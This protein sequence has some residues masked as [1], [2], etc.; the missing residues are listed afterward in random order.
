MSIRIYHKNLKILTQNKFTPEDGGDIEYYKNIGARLI[1][2][3][4]RKNNNLKKQ[5]KY[6]KDFVKLIQSQKIYKIKSEDQDNYVCCVLAL[7]KLGIYDP[8]D[9]D[10]PIYV[11]PKRKSSLGKGLLQKGEQN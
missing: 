8:D 9:A 7:W 4:L 10:S 11:A 6:Y 2:T 1:M 5:I 3:G